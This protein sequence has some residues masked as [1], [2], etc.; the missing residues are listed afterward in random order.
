MF[1]IA[2][3]VWCFSRHLLLMIGMVVPD[4][5]VHYNNFLL[6][7]DIVDIVFSPTASK[8]KAAFLKHLIQEHHVE[9]TRIYPE[10]SVT[11]KCTTIFTLLNL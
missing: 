7:L 1:I 9:F 4:D 6:H 11:P 2:A 5:N 8:E 10:S 3:K